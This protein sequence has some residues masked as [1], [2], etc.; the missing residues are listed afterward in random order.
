ME[1]GGKRI[2]GLLD[3]GAE[4]TIVDRKTAALLQIQ[5]GEDVAARG[6]GKSPITASLAE[7]VQVDVL[8]RHVTLPVVAIMDLSEV[9][10]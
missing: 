8:G 3:S 9:G 4:L 6:T 1:L 5:A 10:G 2:E 7:G